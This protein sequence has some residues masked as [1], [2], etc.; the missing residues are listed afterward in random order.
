MALTGVLFALIATNAFAVVTNRQLVACYM[1]DLEAKKIGGSLSTTLQ[2]IATFTGPGVNDEV[3]RLDPEEMKYLLFKALITFIPGGSDGAGYS[4]TMTS[5]DGKF[6]SKLTLFAVGADCPGFPQKGIIDDKDG[7]VHSLVFKSNRAFIVSNLMKA[8]AKPVQV[9][10]VPLYGDTIGDK[11]KVIRLDIFSIT[12]DAGGGSTPGGGGTPTPGT[13]P[14]VSLVLPD[15]LAAGIPMALG[16]SAVSTVNVSTVASSTFTG[17]VDLST[18][19]DPEGLDVQITPSKI[20]APGNGKAVVTIVTG[21]L[22]LPRDYRVTI[23]AL[24][25]NGEFVGQSS[26]I[27][28]ITCDPPLILG[29]DQP[30]S[31]VVAEGTKVSLTAKVTATGPIFYQWYSGFKGSTNFPVLTATDKT[32]TMNA[33]RGTSEFWM[34]AWNACGSADSETVTVTVSPSTVRP[35]RRH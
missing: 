23:N 9:S 2:D 12:A 31:V 4:F 32:L 30:K 15:P 10:A 22:T 21:P 7:S 6:S 17:D 14:P 25:S 11:S 28:S 26:F 8:S 5:P 16:N 24:N 1:D 29:I 18:S 27:V 19:V 13:A 35:T 33:S 34:R 20:K 3:K